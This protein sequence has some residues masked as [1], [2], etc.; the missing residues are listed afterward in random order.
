MTP[1]DQPD[2][3]RLSPAYSNALLSLCSCHCHCLCLSVPSGEDAARGEERK[4]NGTL[5]QA[6][7]AESMLLC[8]MT[9]SITHLKEQ[10]H[11]WLLVFDSKKR[12]SHSPL[13]ESIE[14]FH[15]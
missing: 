3:L 14:E 10:P 4:G 13:E 5:S 8:E 2:S 15:Y 11:H 12:A 9:R 1:L 6:N 7:N